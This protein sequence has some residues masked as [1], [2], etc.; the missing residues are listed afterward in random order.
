MVAVVNVTLE[1]PREG[2]HFGGYELTSS[3]VVCNK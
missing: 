2:Q 1:G 3:P